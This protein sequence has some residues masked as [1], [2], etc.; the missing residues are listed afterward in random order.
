MQQISDDVPIGNRVGFFCGKVSENSCPQ[1]ISLEKRRLDRGKFGKFEKK[2][3]YF[4]KIDIIIFVLVT[5]W[6]SSVGRA[7]H[8]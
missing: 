1:K 7:L 4:V 2:L 6:N 3:A 5:R 8:S